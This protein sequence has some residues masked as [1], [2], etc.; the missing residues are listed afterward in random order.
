MKKS[1]VFSSRAFRKGTLSVILTAVVIVAVLLVN[2][3][4]TAVSQRYPF[5][6][7]LTANKDYTIALSEEY[8]NFV[9]NI[10]MDVEMIV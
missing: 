8:E 5:S 7:D 9:K 3:L 6:V 2:V 10:D 1:S 4:A